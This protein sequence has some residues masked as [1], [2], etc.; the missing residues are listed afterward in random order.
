MPF[1]PNPSCGHRRRTKEPAE[2]VAGSLFCSDCGTPLTATAPVFETARDAEIMSGGRQCPECGSMNGS[3]TVRCSCGHDSIKPRSLI[4][5]PERVD[6]SPEQKPDG[7]IQSRVLNIEFSGSAGE[8]FRIWVV[9]LCLT[10]V[11]L[12]LFSAWAKVRK[13]R[14]F[15]SCTK[16]DNTPFQ[17]LG[18][19]IPILKGRLIAGAAFLAYYLSSHFFT[20]FLP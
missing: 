10:L 7:D 17:Y 3:D 9:N 11:T 6:P 19:P 20:S 18:R 14:Y 1:C 4:V 15:Y 2:F 5:H 16:L 8:Y 13:K 12:G